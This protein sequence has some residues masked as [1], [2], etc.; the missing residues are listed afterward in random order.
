MY[1]RQIVN[2]PIELEKLFVILEH[3]LPDR[4]QLGQIARQVTS[5]KPEDLPAGEQLNRILDAAAGLTR[6][7]ACLL[8]TSRCV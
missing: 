7:E 8:Y 6:Y 5:D 3:P 1:K 2:I 4:E